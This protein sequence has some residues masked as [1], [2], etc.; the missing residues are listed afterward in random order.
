M[1]GELICPMK[2]K[3]PHILLKSKQSSEFNSTVTALMCWFQNHAVFKDDYGVIRFFRRCICDSCRD[4]SLSVYDNICVHY[5]YS[6]VLSASLMPTLLMTSASGSTT[7]FMWQ[8]VCHM[9][10]G[11]MDGDI[12][13]SVKCSQTTLAN[14]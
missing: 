5:L 9:Q 7:E 3:H 11:E 6:H 4:F 8:S 14:K 2:T 10:P 1:M 13:M 12:S